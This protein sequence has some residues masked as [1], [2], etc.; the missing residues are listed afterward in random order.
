MADVTC[1]VNVAVAVPELVPVAVNV[2][3]P[4]PAVAG[5]ANVPNEKVGNTSEIVSVKSILLLRENLYAIDDIDE[6]IGLI[7]V[8]LLMRSNGSTI[9]ADEMIADDDTLTE[10]AKTAEALN[11]A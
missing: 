5:T 9:A 2:V 1:N 6:V 4:Q 8:S 11:S 7:I 10:E 3:L